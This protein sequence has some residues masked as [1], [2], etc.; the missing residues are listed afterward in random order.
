MY[1]RFWEISERE[2]KKRTD[3]D[4][5]M[6]NRKLLDIFSRKDETDKASDLKQL[7]IY[8]GMRVMVEDCNGN[9]LFVASLQNPQGGEALLHQYSAEE[10]CDAHKEAAVKLRGYND[11]E[12][13]AVFMEGF[14]TPKQKHIWQ[15]K[16]I[17]I[18]R[19]EN[20]RVFTRLSTNIEAAV[21][22]AEGADAKTCRL[23]NISAGGVSISAEQRYYK[24]DRF[25]LKVRLLEDRPF[26]VLYCEVL[27]V[28][29]RAVSRF[30]YGCRFLELTEADQEEL[31]Q[32]MTWFAQEQR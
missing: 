9:P 29:E 24:G 1:G 22:K 11:C 7:E 13:K 10:A 15:L 19:I 26:S 14:M 21:M 27:R 5:H 16:D 28:A 3:S 2:D 30:E 12:R 6:G 25:L 32:H 20:E 8:S 4:R 18:T 31:M 17:H 23:L